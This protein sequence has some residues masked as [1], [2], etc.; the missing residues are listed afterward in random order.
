ML[1]R[2]RMTTSIAFYRRCIS[3]RLR[4]EGHRPL[5]LRRVEKERLRQFMLPL[6]IKN[7]MPNPLLYRST[8]TA[9]PRSRRGKAS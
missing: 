9:K 5:R 1:A 6:S 4:L 3:E 8:N 2:S 7:L